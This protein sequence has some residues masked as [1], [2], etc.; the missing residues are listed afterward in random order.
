MDSPRSR[1]RAQKGFSLVEL[2]CVIAVMSIVAVVTATSIQHTAWA[3]VKSGAST[4]GNTVDYARQYAIFNRCQ[5]ALVVAT[6]ENDAYRA[7]T[8]L[9]KD[10]TNWSP[11]SRWQKLPEG[12]IFD[13]VTQTSFFNAEPDPAMK[14]LTQGGVSLEPGTGYKSLLFFSNGQIDGHNPTTLRVIQGHWDAEGLKPQNT[15]RYMDVVMIPVSGKVKY[16]AP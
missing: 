16:S 8:V 4:L 1:A 14:T 7:F 2:M 5:T 3:N 13:S 15:N 10:D 9:K 12:V 11:V 6:Q